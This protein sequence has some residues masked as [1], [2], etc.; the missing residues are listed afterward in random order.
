MSALFP[1]RLSLYLSGTYVRNFL[2]LASV[3]LGIVYLFDTVELLRRAAKF[4]D[5]PIFLVLQMGLFKLPEVGQ[6]VLPFA[7]LFS[8][9]FTFWQLTRRYELIAVRAAGLSIWQI[10]SPIIMTA[11][12]IGALQIAVI[13][14]FGALMIGK[15]E[16]WES[17]SLKR[18]TSLIA[19]SKQ[20]LWL[21]QDQDNGHVILHAGNIDSDNWILKK[22]IVL[23]FDD[24]YGF[25]RRLD[26]RQAELKPGEWS[27]QEVVSNRPRELPEKSDF[28]SMAT[29][30]TREDIEDSFASPETISFWA[31]PSFIKTMENTGFDPIRLKIHYQVLLSQPLLYLAMVLLAACVSLRPPRSGGTFILIVGGIFVGFMIFFTSSFLQ[32]LGASHQ[33]P[34]SLSAWAPALIATLIGATIIM[35]LEDG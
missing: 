34:V 2:F 30:L 20:G 21:K 8:A 6:L 35:N 11:V 33:I 5:V 24:N 16:E 13:N 25:V 26:A 28:I 19:L 22:I 18:Q 32:A 10:L 29:D 9:I 4:D 23:F 3:I 17:T 7:V 12:V 31:M 27:F 1:P 14:P 15:F